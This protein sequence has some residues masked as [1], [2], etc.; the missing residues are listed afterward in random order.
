MGKA[1]CLL[2]KAES[3]GD[4]VVRGCFFRHSFHFLPYY[5]DDH[6]CCQQGKTDHDKERI[7]QARP[8]GLS[9]GSLFQI[10]AAFFDVILKAAVPVVLAEIVEEDLFQLL[11]TIAVERILAA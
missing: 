11:L 6:G 1:I 5:S 2:R 8:N 9:H 3:C 7:E 10:D 4:V